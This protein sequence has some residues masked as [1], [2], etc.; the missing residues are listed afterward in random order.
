MGADCRGEFAN[1]DFSPA[2]KIVVAGVAS[3]Y[4][5]AGVPEFP[6]AYASKGRQRWMAAGVLGAA[7]HIAR[8]LGALGE[9]VRLCTVVG[10]DTAGTAI[11][12]EL[13]QCG[14]LGTG[15]VEGEESSLGV[16]LVAPDGSRMGLPHLEP[17][18]HV[19]YPF[20]TLRAAARD[21]DLLVLTN[22]KFVRPL[23][24]PAARLGVPIAVDVHLIADLDDEYNRPWLEAADVVFC[25]HERLPWP[26]ETWVARL[27]D[28]YPRCR[29]AGVGLGARGALLGT[30]DGRLLEVAAVAP[31]GV[32][33]TS[34]AGDALFATFLRTWLR[35]QD[36]ARA[37]RSAVTHA[38]WKIGHRLPV[39]ASLTGEQ[40]AELQRAHSPRLTCRRL[41]CDETS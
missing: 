22:A 33:N 10:R 14:L 35:T 34:G 37:L 12:A 38:G 1:E 8:I 30:R 31:G 39:E 7:G 27:L 3:L 21:A 29:L 19:P 16:V 41:T 40:L 26:P 36:P 2:R 23:V 20:A 13:D 24:G 6:L 11:R 15:V 4:L 32:V 18:D 25:S 5:S 9:D 28:R 17:V